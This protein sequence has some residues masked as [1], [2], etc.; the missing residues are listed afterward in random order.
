MYYIFSRKVKFLH[1]FLCII[2]HFTPVARRRVMLVHSTCLRVIGIGR[3]RNYYATALE[4]SCLRGKIYP[5]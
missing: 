2:F 5:A 1:L 3:W 4:L